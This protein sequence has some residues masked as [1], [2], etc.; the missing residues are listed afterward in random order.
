MG[1]EKIDITSPEFVLAMVVSFMS[2]LGMVFGILALLI[3]IIGLPIIALALVFHYIGGFFVGFLMLHKTQ[4][5]LAKLALGAGI[6]IPLPLLTIG[7]IAA[8]IL[9]NKLIAFIT[10]QAAIAAIAVATGGA[11]LALEGA[12]AT[13]EVAAA[14]AE[15]AATGGKIAAE[16]AKVAGAAA[17]VAEGG[18]AAAGAGAAEEVGATETAAEEA[19]KGVPEEALGVEKEPWEKVKEVMENLPQPEAEKGEEGEYNKEVEANDE[20]NELNLKNTT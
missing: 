8:I 7:I 12:A 15:I 3:P 14:G 16:G 18:E 11:G 10:E 2:D 9:S 20:N 17:K 6:L 5:W 4:G 1:K 13:G 19:I